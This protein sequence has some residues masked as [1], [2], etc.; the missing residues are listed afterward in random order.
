MDLDLFQEFCAN[1]V[2]ICPKLKTAME[3][4]EESAG[5][6]SLQK[7]VREHQMIKFVLIEKNF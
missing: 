2:V 3:E 6:K 4:L 5:K 7:P 1:F